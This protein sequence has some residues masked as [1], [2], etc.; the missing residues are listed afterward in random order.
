MCRESLIVLAYLTFSYG[1]AFA[2]EKTKVELYFASENVVAG[3]KAGN[4]VDLKRLAGRS[5]TPSGKISVVTNTIALDLEVASISQIEKPK[6]PEQA[7][8]VE[9]KA[10]KIQAARIERAK[11]QLVTIMETDSDGT[12]KTTMKPVTLLLDLT[13]E[14]KK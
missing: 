6:S 12:V 3:L 14:K 5:I 7:V 1:L 10:T 8:K 9:L 2:Q 13:E 4:R 11:A